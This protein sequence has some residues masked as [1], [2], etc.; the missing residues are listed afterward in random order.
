MEPLGRP[1]AFMPGQFVFVNFRSLALRRGVPPV[2]ALGRAQ[3]SRSAPGRSA[4]SSIPSRS[5]PP[6]ASRAAG[7]GQGGRRLHARPAPARARR[8]R[9]RRRPVRLLLAPERP[10]GRQIWLAGGIGVTPFLSMARSLGRPKRAVDR[11]LLLRRARARRRTSSTSSARSRRAATTSASPSSRETRRLPHRERA[12]PR[13]S[14]PRLLGRAHL[15]P[16]GDDRQPARRSS[17]P[18]AF[19]SA[20]PCRGVRLRQARAGRAARAPPRKR[21]VTAARPRRGT[22]RAP[23]LLVAFALVVAGHAA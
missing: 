17:R 1:L 16:A 22:R 12:S 8:G 13:S 23:R 19:R 15:R 18:S 21:P 2:R 9:R 4:T 6:R 5:P 20:H 11:L 14:R 3:V 10:S 7:H